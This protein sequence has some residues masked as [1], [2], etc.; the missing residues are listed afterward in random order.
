MRRPSLPLVLHAAMLYR[1]DPLPDNGQL[2][3]R[4]RQISV[5]YCMLLE[6]FIQNSIFQRRGYAEIQSDACSGVEA[7]QIA[8]I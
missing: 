8:V 1:Q 2:K 3:P 4:R 7:N 5:S 6:P